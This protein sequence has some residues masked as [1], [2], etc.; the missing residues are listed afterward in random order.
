MVRQTVSDSFAEVVLGHD[1]SQKPLTWKRYNL[2]RFRSS[3]LLQLP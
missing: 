3:L 1:I 2:S